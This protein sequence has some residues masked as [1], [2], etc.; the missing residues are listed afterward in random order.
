LFEQLARS[1]RELVRVLRSLRETPEL[2]LPAP[3]R[4]RFAGAAG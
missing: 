3:R 2:V 4:M 1:Y